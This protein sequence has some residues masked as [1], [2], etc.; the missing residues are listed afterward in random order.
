MF[1]AAATAYAIRQAQP[2][3]EVLLRSSMV[4]EKCLSTVHIK[5]YRRQRVEV[6]RP[7]GLRLGREGKGSKSVNV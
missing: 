1:D 5:M 3:Y 2:C 7:T 6:N 4:H